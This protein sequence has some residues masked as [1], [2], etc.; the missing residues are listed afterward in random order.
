MGG[1]AGGLRQVRPEASWC[2]DSKGLCRP[3]QGQ[4]LRDVPR[5]AR[6]GE[7]LTALPFR[8]LHGGRQVCDHWVCTTTIHGGGVGAQ[9]A[10]TEGSRRSTSVAC[11]SSERS[12]RRHV[13]HISRY[14]QQ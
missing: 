1:A 12:Q 7:R 8:E 11:A 14:V 3:F 4:R 9:G 2:Q 5:G 13:G 6:G 10:G